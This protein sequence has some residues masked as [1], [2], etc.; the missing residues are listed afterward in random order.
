MVDDP[1]MK[2]FRITVKNENGDI[3]YLNAFMVPRV[4]DTIKVLGKYRGTVKFV[5]HEF[6]ELGENQSV[7]IFIESIS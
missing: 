1:P 7:V 2:D 4:G 3:R 5:N 6:D